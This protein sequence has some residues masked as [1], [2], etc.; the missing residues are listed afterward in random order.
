MPDEPYAFP[1]DEL[2]TGLI[3]LSREGNGD[4]VTA[5]T[6][7]VR[8]QGQHISDAD[9]DRIASTDVP[10]GEGLHAAAAEEMRRRGTWRRFRIRQL[11]GVYGRA[12]RWLTG[13]ALLAL[14][15]LAGV[16]GGIVGLKWLLT[17]MGFL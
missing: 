15:L 3:E 2:L 17:V 5:L 11:A 9:M 7:L 4:A 14:L 13:I 8:E 6:S 1:F 16:F 12:L 10:S